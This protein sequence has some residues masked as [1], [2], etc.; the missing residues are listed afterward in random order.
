MDASATGEKCMELL[1]EIAKSYSCRVNP[2]HSLMRARYGLYG[3]PLEPDLFDID[4]PLLRTAPATN[5]TYSGVV[6]STVGPTT[7]GVS[8]GGIPLTAGSGLANVTSG[9]GA[10]S[11]LAYSDEVLFKDLMNL[12]HMDKNLSGPSAVLNIGSASRCGAEQPLS[13]YLT[14]LLEVEPLHFTCHATSDGTRM[15]RLDTRMIFVFLNARVLYIDSFWTVLS[16]QLHL[17]QVP[18]NYEFDDA[19]RNWD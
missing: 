3:S 1:G 4:P 17:P 7:G 13:R 14:G 16:L 9:S 2:Y 12:C 19:T 5:T 8:A 18:V 10:N 6:A 11:S 15:E